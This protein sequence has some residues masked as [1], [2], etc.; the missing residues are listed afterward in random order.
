MPV[1]RTE[2]DADTGAKK[3]R[4]PLCA[5]KRKICCPLPDNMHKL[6]GL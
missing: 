6:S 2:I 1:E 5:N 4:K 3:G